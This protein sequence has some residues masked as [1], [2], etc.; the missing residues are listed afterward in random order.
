MNK[1]PIKLA[2]ACALILLLIVSNSECEINY[3]TP[4]SQNTNEVIEMA[5]YPKRRAKAEENKII[6]SIGDT[7]SNFLDLTYDKITFDG[8]S[9][10][11]ADLTELNEVLL[12][13]ST[14]LY[15]E[16][17][18]IENC[19]RYLNFEKFENLHHEDYVLET[20][21]VS[22]DKKR[23]E[24]TFKKVDKKS[25]TKIINNSKAIDVSS[26]NYYKVLSSINF[27]YNYRQ[28]I[29]S[30]TNNMSIKPMNTTVESIKVDEQGPLDFVMANTSNGKNTDS[31][32]HG[33]GSQTGLTYGSDDSIVKLFPRYFFTTNGI[34]S[35]GGTEWGYLVNTYNDIGHNKNI[36]LIIYD[37]NQ[38][39]M[40][41][42]SGE[43]TEI[44]VLIHKNYK[45]YYEE[46]V[47]VGDID[48]TYSLANPA[49][50]ENIR[51]FQPSNAKSSVKHLNP[52]DS[53][54][55]QLN[56]YGYSFSTSAAYYKG[57]DKNNWGGA[58]VPT[59]IGLGSTIL[60]TALIPSGIGFGAQIGVSLVADLITDKII[61]LTS[62]ATK[63]EKNVYLSDNNGYKSC[64]STF[65]NSYINYD[66]LRRDKKLL[67][68][69]NFVLPNS[70]GVYETPERDKPLLFKDEQC[71]ISYRTSLLA[72]EQSDD[73]NA[74]VSHSL[75]LEVI[76]DTT[77]VFN[78]NVEFVGT[79][80]HYWAYSFGQNFAPKDIVLYA[81]G[82]MTSIAFGTVN[83]QIIYFKPLNTGSYYIYMNNLPPYVKCIIKDGGK[84]IG[85]FKVKFTSRKDCWNNDVIYTENHTWFKQGNFKEGITYT[86]E[87]FANNGN[88]NI[89]GSCNIGIS[90]NGGSFYD[91][92]ETTATKKAK[93]TVSYN[94]ENQII[95]F[96]P[97]S[98]STYDFCTSNINDSTRV[99][100]YISLLDSNFNVLFS[101]YDSS[102][103][104][105][106]YFFA[107]LKSNKTYYISTRNYYVSNSNRYSLVMLR[108]KLLPEIRGAVKNIGFNL[109]FKGVKYHSFLMNQNSTISGNIRF[110]YIGE[111]VGN[112]PYIYFNI[113]DCKGSIVY[114]NSFSYTKDF[115]F[116]FGYDSPYLINVYSTS[117]ST[118]EYI[119]LLLS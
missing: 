109:V 114:S 119:D 14:Y 87:I 82:N 92:S 73:Y 80:S 46:D 105:G 30:N 43:L 51:Y 104:T 85:D 25:A 42:I 34:R 32:V 57:R 26:E 28:S 58:A 118:N 91:V 31:D 2:I 74:I 45:Y 88:L 35:G 67:K 50:K 103:K 95:K 63:D 70:K 3:N 84:Q 75:K 97:K 11:V 39:K 94:K 86:I 12:Q 111:N 117:S 17:K 71:L 102:G 41:A 19:S 49:Y 52:G 59:L 44:R 6:T 108:G 76:N 107:H 13:S 10:Y 16:I 33:S 21:K 112:K 99:G 89:S 24:K 54:Y 96:K 90:Y 65:F 4:I 100:T 60:Q 47:V 15:S 64:S 69:V 20:I 62:S 98:E 93:K 38:E 29:E 61:S 18:L 106:G 83:K 36:S 56:D 113:V 101:S 81:N 110:E 27:E 48:N 116:S 66:Y 78:G 23:V 37:I 40:T 72:S 9:Y 22:K 7:Y 68:E 5:N 79:I 77:R 53:G 1:K 8:I 115:K 55:N